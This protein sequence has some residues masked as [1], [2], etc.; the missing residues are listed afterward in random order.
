MKIATLQDVADLAGVSAGTV[1]KYINGQKIRPRNAQLVQ[2]AIEELNY[3][4]SSLARNFARGRT[5]DVLLFV[6]VEHPI[7]S[8]TW[9]YELPMIQGANDLLRDT[10][11]NLKMEIAYAT[12][13]EQNRQRLQDCIAGRFVDAIMLLTPWEIDPDLVDILDESQLPYVLLGGS[14]EINCKV[15]DFDNET[16]IYDLVTQLYKDGHRRFA[17][18]SGFKNQLHTIR[19]ERGFLNAV[20]DLG[21]SEVDT[22][23]LHGDYS[24]NSGIEMA[25]ELLTL[26]NPP[27]AFICGNDYIAA[28][29][30]RS[31]QNHGLSVPDSVAV[32]GFDDTD[33]AMAVT[34]TITSVKIPSYDIGKIAAAELL[35]WLND[36][37]YCIQSPAITCQIVYRQSTASSFPKEG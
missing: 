13:P 27:T 16:P 12:N 24:L 35:A 1:S 31:I 37:N 19:R 3:K 15:F 11:Y 30:I 28:G 8:S 9:L 21:L 2:K 14:N 17:M 23:M 22:P 18:L 20:R 25:D 33:V 10:A 6:I 4:P 34:P 36:D 29:A 5:F 7:V 26:P 32:T